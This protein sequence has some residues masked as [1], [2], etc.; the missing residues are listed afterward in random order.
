MNTELIN[1]ATTIATGYLARNVVSPGEI[2]DLIH[3]IAEALATVG[4]MPTD[5]VRIL[6]PVCEPAVPIEESITD[7][8]LICLEDGRRCKFLKRH[9]R[10]KYNLSPEQYR[11]RWGLPDGYPMTAPAHSRRRR[12]IAN[13]VQGTFRRKAA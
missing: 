1:A 8:F 13:A 4:E 11:E 5:P 12:E 10:T 2:A 3:H 9:L 7:Q 6:P